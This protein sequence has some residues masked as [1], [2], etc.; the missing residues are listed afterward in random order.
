[1]Y[2]WKNELKTLDFWCQCENNHSSFSHKESPL[3]ISV[4]EAHHHILITQLQLLCTP[5][6]PVKLSVK[7][8]PVI[9]FTRLVIKLVLYYQS[10]CFYQSICSKGDGRCHALL[11][12]FPK[13][14]DVSAIFVSSF[15]LSII[16]QKSSDRH[17][18]GWEAPFHTKNEEQA[19][20]LLLSPISIL[21]SYHKPISIGGLSQ[22]GKQA[23]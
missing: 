16:V 10:V 2:I 15:G 8:K 20:Y 1:M 9:V 22:C 17:S 11:F 19:M 4:L 12:G 5:H 18:R 21:A 6:K 23:I 14:P 3:S 7:S 13:I